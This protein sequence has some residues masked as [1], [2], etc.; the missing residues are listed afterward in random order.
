MPINMNNDDMLSI[1]KIIATW[2]D[3]ATTEPVAQFRTLV[4]VA[5]LESSA[6]RQL[7]GVWSGN[8]HQDA[9]NLVYW[10]LAQDENPEDDRFTVLGS[11]LDVL[12]KDPGV[13]MN[14]R[15]EL[16]SLIL[17]YRLYLSAEL[18]DDL[19]VR[20]Q[21]PRSRVKEG[22]RS[23][24]RLPT[25]DRD[26]AVELGKHIDPIEPTTDKELQGWLKPEPPPLDIG[27]LRIA[28]SR[29][30]SVCRVDV[31]NMERT[32]TGVL[33]GKDLVL[34]NYHVIN[35]TGNENVTE[36]LAQTKLSFGFVSGPVGSSD[37][38]QTFSL[39]E[40]APVSF[41]PTDELDFALL[42]V[43]KE[44]RKARGLEA[45]PFAKGVPSKGNGLHIIQHPNGETMKL[46]LSS[47]GVTAVDN[48]TGLFQYVTKTAGGSSGAPCFNDDWEIVGLH[49]AEVPKPFGA[50]REGILFKLILNRIQPQLEPAA[51]IL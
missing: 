13:S 22:E 3:A 45:P 26:G 51:E 43:A 12:L 40:T 25:R 18:I 10:A 36:N 46:A 41:S 37:P 5:N 23:Y 30:A 24:L 28:L 7:G 8:S 32:G 27:F 14:Y 33:V 48:D 4:R 16:V 20:F 1:V 47:N 9:V 29:T 39:A 49:H 44:I 21:V 17:A 2:A 50:V 42:R 34:T 19:L 31:A 38:V 6:K 11:L 15:R 35:Y